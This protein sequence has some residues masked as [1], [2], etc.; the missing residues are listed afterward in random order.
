MKQDYAWS[1]LHRLIEIQDK[2]GQSSAT[3]VVEFL[4]KENMGEKMCKFLD[5]LAH[6]YKW[7]KEKSKYIK[8]RKK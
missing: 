5:C 4:E 2:F 8:R 3:I 1:A 6:D 7:D